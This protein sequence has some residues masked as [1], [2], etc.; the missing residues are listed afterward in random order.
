MI[1][2]LKYLVSQQIAF[3]CVRL[4]FFDMFFSSFS[5]FSAEY[6][7][8]SVWALRTWPDFLSLDASSTT[9]SC[10]FPLHFLHSSMFY[11]I[12][13][14]FELQSAMYSVYSIFRIMPYSHYV[15][16]RKVT[17]SHHSL[18]SIVTYNHHVGFESRPTAIL[19]VS[20]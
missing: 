1:I 10:S 17:Y 9:V 16:F 7:S 5:F 2:Y 11:C 18:F 14:D 15:S 6:L 13:V 3:I 4:F 12:A 19:A 8:V 20:A